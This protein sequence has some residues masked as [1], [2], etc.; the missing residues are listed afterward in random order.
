MSVRI[1]PGPVARGLLAVAVAAAAWGTGGAVAA[2]LYAGAGLGPLAVSFW[3][4]VGGALLLAAARA[5]LRPS[6]GGS[7]S[8]RRLVVTGA[9]LAVYQTAYF[10][11]VRDAGLALST[12]VT[13]GAGPVLIAVG[14]RVVAAE[15]LS[16]AGSVAV[17]GSLVGLVLLVSGSG[18]DGVRVD[19]A[20]LRGI[21]YALLSATGYAAT[22]VLTRRLDR[23]SP[24]DPYAVAMGGFV[25]GAVCLLP[26]AFAEGFLPGRGA[27]WS[28]LVLLGYLAAVPT[29]LA[30]GLFFAGLAAVRAT[31]ASVVALLEPLTAAVI[32]V[33]LLGERLTPAVVA[34]AVVLLAAV[35]GLAVDERRAATV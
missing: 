27:G 13:L 18:G 4:F 5:V 17:A 21:G 33:L 26:L 20:T 25:V 9:G 22:T 12:M 19:A 3:R 30:Y 16:R 7:P 34:G 29:A 8:V 11:A 32:A 2:V 28:S 14:A 1:V 35:V 10:A 31:T 15:R 24:S 6:G 23:A